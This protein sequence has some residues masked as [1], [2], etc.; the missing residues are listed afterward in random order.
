MSA[1]G[2]L[3]RA[4]VIEFATHALL[5]GNDTSIE[6]GLTEPALVLTPPPAG[7][8]QSELEYDDGLLT[9]SEVAQLNLNADWV[10]LSA[11]NTAG[12]EST[13]GEA[14]SGLARAFF[15]A[16]TRALLV[17]HWEVDSEAA[18]KLTT[19]VFAEMHEHPDLTRS[20]GLRRSMAALV[21]TGG[22]NAHPSV[23]A[24]FVLV[25]D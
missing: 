1:S 13:G 9:A 21:A 12:G 18:V 22:L 4:R 20:E 15:F 7:R 5:P 3:A 10:V 14:L 25:G 11:C 23:W 24:P 19:R 16:G 2:M 17:S 8:S 6:R